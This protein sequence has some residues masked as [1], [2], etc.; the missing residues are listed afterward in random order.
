MKSCLNWFHNNQL[1]ANPEKFQLM[2]LGINNDTS[3]RLR[4][5]NINIKSQKHVK[6]VGVE[7]D[8]KLK[9]VSHKI[10]VLLQTGK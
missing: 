3:L 9:F 10:Y 2:F 6:L 7:I 1:V 8:N 4:I 5:D